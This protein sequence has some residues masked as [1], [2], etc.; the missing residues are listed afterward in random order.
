MAR[1]KEGVQ[2]ENQAPLEEE[3]PEVH[4]DESALA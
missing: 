1:Q 2:Q 3:V 4:L